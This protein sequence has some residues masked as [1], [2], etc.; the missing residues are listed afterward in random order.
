MSEIINTW[1]AGVKSKLQT[2]FPHAEVR[3][4]EP[5]EEDTENQRDRDLILVWLGTWGAQQRDIALADPNLQIRYLPTR[6]RKQ[7]RRESP[8]DPAVVYQAL[9]DVMTALKPYRR[10]GD[11]APRVAAYISAAQP[12]TQPK[13]NWYAQLTMTGASAHLATEAA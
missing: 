4:G 8:D 11:L 13:G 6:S 1:V 5:D 9:E 3:V 7:P 10:F 2:A 12:V